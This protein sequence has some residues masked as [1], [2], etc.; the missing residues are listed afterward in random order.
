MVDTFD[1]LAK[2]SGDNPPDNADSTPNTSDL[3]KVDLSAVINRLNDLETA[4]NEIRRTQAASKPDPQTEPT[5]DPQT[6][7]K[8]DPPKQDGE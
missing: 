8:T 1:A 5:P 4:I 2:F 6:E 3:A 7:P